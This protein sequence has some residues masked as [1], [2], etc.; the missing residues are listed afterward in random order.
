[1]VRRIPTSGRTSDDAR[2][3]GAMA[4]PHQ[5]HAIV[6]CAVGNLVAAGTGTGA[7][8]VRV[9]RQPPAWYATRA[10]ARR[11]RS[12]PSVK[13][14][15]TTARGLLGA[16]RSSCGEVQVHA[17][18]GRAGHRRFPTVHRGSYD[19]MNATCP[20]CELIGMTTSSTKACPTVR[21]GERCTADRRTHIETLA[22]LRDAADRHRPD[23][24]GR[25]RYCLTAW[26]CSRW[27]DI[28]EV[29][30]AFQECPRSPGHRSSPTGIAN[31]ML[32]P[33]HP[34][35]DR[36]PTHGHPAAA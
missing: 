19:G 28:D 15:D 33:P 2:P 20:P 30:M 4:A 1:M 10:G 27:Q 16:R 18:E 14:S 7:R 34:T 23:E 5:A 25:C 31:A 13:G 11:P 36:R 8:P 9:R 26:P 32:A 29:F 12:V 35:P 24:P 3:P 21:P 17:D 22:T 6:R